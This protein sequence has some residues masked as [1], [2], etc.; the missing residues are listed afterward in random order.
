MKAA[1][2]TRYGPPDV[3]QITD[4]EYGFSRITDQPEVITWTYNRL[5]GDVVTNLDIGQLPVC[6]NSEATYPLLG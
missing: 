4:A 3:V 2:C 1:V 6:G 5:R